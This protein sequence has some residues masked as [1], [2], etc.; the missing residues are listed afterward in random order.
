MEPRSL[1]HILNLPKRER[2][3]VMAEGLTLLAEHIGTL[4][5]DLD[6][7]RDQGR[8][9]AMAAI[10]VL[11]SEEAAKVLILLDVARMGW[12][13]QEAVD[14]Q[15][16]RFYNHLA[17]GIYTRV[18]DG[19]PADFAEVRRY[20]D[21]LRQSHFLDG[22]N[23]VD[24]IFRNEVLAARE[25]SLYVDYLSAE[26]GDYWATPASRDDIM[27]SQPSM[28]IRLVTALDRMGCLSMDGLQIIEAVW[29]G[30]TI[31]DETRWHVIEDLN[32]KVVDQLAQRGLVKDG[33]TDD[34]AYLVYQQW[35][36]PLGHMDLHQ[37]EVKRAELLARR[38]RWLADQ[39]W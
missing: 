8:Q 32:Q 19:R 38:N 17:R 10:D 28:I 7:L 5:T 9:R 3:A 27:I 13:D 23:D 1:V 34:D 33:A 12:G 25:D 18:V 16:K 31:E 15:L 39:E 29:R 2:F 24:W 14:R 36:F 37:T 22:P 4:H 35:T 20:V 26:G 21:G 6:R 30:Q 11:A